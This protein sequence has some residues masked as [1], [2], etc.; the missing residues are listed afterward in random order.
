MYPRE[1]LLLRGSSDIPP[2]ILETYPLLREAVL[3]KDSEGG[4]ESRY[5]VPDCSDGRVT[6]SDFTSFAHAPL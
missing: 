4:L 3:C 2:T 5:R 1:Y 6:E